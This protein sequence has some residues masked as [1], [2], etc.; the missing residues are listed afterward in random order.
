[1]RT[2]RTFLSKESKPDPHHQKIRKI[3]ENFDVDDPLAYAQ[4]IA[5]AT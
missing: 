2:I 4:N 3:A 1:M 5:N